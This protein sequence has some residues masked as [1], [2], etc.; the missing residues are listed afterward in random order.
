MK[1]I[2]VH[3]KGNQPTLVWEDAADVDCGP[4]EVVVD[5]H[6]TAVNRADLLQARGLYPP[7]P[8]DSEILGL[9]MSGEIMKMGAKV[10]DW[11]IGDRVCSLAPGGGYAEHAVVHHK[12]LLPLPGDWSFEQGAAI[13]EAWLTAYSN[14]FMEGGLTDGET[15][16]IHAGAS[17]VG[18]AAI[19]LARSAGAHVVITAGSEAKLAKCRELG[20]EVVINYKEDDF[21]TAV[22]AQSPAGGVDLILD[23]VGGSYLARHLDILRPYGRLINIGVLG[24]GKGEMDMTVLLMKSLKLMGTRMRA[25]SKDEKNRINLGFR[26]RFWRLLMSGHLNPILDSSYPITE[27]DAAHAHVQANRNIGKVVL[28]IKGPRLKPKA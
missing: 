16:L 13:P 3:Q 9:E 7:P 15:V 10:S 8:G 2:T 4:E 23:C 20:A 25:R 22:K 24:G 5:I 26:E 12:M 1:A 19:Q 17:G 11:Q 27:A 28:K 21:A 14:L 6:A 18:T